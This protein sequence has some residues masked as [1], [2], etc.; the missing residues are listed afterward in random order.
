MWDT[1]QEQA[2]RKARSQAWADTESAYYRSITLIVC[3][4]VG[5][6]AACA[7]AAFIASTM[8]GR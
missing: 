4:T 8:A 2:E 1:P 7:T 5:F 6:C 3:K